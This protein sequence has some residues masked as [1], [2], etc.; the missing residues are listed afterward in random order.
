MLEVKLTTTDI[1]KIDR[2]DAEKQTILVTYT[3]DGWTWEDLYGAP[4]TAA[5]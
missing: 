1:I 4:S 5:S 3:R 2:L